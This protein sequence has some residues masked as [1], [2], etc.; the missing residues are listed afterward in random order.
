MLY[1][2]HSERLNG[3]Y[4]YR[5]GGIQQRRYAKQPSTPAYFLSADQLLP[6]IACIDTLFSVPPLPPYFGVLHVLV[7]WDGTLASWRP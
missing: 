1:N 7:C 3:G 4:N 5:W 2:L 6:A